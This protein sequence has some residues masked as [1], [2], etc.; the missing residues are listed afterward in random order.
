L[1]PAKAPGRREKMK[2]NEIGEIKGNSSLKKWG[3]SGVDILDR[4]GLTGILKRL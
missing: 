2:D 4:F 1:N 3:D